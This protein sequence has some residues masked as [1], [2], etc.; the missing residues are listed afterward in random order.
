MGQSGSSQRSVGVYLNRYSGVFGA[1]LQGLLIVSLC[2]L[3][4]LGVFFSKHGLFSEVSYLYGGG[5]VF[6]LL[7]LFFLSCVYSIRFMLLL[8]QGGVGLSLGFSSSF[9]I[10]SILRFLGSVLNL[11]GACVF[12]EFVSLVRIWSVCLVCLQVLGC[13]VGAVVYFW[14]SYNPIKESTLCGGDCLVNSVYCGSVRG[15]PASILVF[16]RWEVYLIS[17]FRRILSLGFNYRV[18]FFSFNFMVFSL[19]FVLLFCFFFV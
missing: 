5:R 12:D 2:G 18:A 4:F 10:I 3:P 14:E 11:L 1:V 9:F 7:F 6:I 15:F 13:L 16:Y 19:V 8:T 17:Q